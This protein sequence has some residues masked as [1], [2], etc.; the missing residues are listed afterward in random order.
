M[1][2]IN[3]YDLNYTDAFKLG[4]RNYANFNGRVSRSEYWRFVAGVTLIQGL[5]GILALLCSTLGFPNYE[6]L[7][8]NVAVGVSLFF[9]IPNIAITARRMHDIGR[10]G[11]TQ[12]ISFIPV[13]GFF[14][15]L[16]Y[17][18]R[19]GDE[20]E[21]SYGERTGY[22]PI[23]PEVSKATGL[24]ETPSRRQDWAMGI[25]IFII[26]SIIIADIIREILWYGMVLM[27]MDTYNN[28]LYLLTIS[29]FYFI[30]V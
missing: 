8:D 25:A 28:H 7:I 1:S 12:L 27:G 26:Q 15:F 9:I 19:R 21:N 18:L 20:R 17:E 14:I 23:T 30:K 4:I 6:T 16:V 3:I 5:L 11:W 29:L 2:T 10:S 13:I 22:T 24:E